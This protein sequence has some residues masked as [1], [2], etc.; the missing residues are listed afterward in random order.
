MTRFAPLWQ[1]EASYSAS[2]DRQIM[3]SLWPDP[4]SVGMAVTAAGGT[5]VNIAPGKCAVPTQTNTGTTLCVSDANEQKA[6]PSGPSGN[7]RIDLLIVR[8]RGV[9]LDGYA[10]A[11]WGFDYVQG[12]EAAT[13]VAPAT[14]VG[15]VALARI[16]RAKG[17]AA[18]AAGDITDVRPGNLSVYIPA[19]PPASNPRG[20]VG[21][22]TGP[23]TTVTIGTTST[24]VM[25]LTVPVVA[26]RR[27]KITGY[28]AG[29]LTTAAVVFMN[30]NGGDYVPRIF[31]FGNS[32]QPS[33][34]A[35]A[36]SATIHSPSTSGNAT[37]SITGFTNT[38]TFTVTANQAFLLVEDIGSQ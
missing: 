10:N 28:V 26:G 38:A 6:M 18:I 8:P 9:E 32:V 4:R 35:A 2:M 1:Q 16:N 24:T 22:A 29:S 37:Y 11:E 14:P 13:P 17:S 21:W 33:V 25:T 27:Y 23:A 31:G 20:F 3:G 34:A 36:T 15:T 19:A 5:T 12:V 30:L 7:P